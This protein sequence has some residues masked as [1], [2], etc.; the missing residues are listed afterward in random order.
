MAWWL[1]LAM[2]AAGQCVELEASQEPAQMIGIRQIEAADEVHSCP[3]SSSPLPSTSPIEAETLGDSSGTAHPPQDADHQLSNQ[4]MKKR[5]VQWH[6]WTV[7]TN[8][9]P[10]A[11]GNG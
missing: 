6:D 2:L 11:S 8:S 3:P 1:L 5:K 10:N 9:M 4:Q 7:R